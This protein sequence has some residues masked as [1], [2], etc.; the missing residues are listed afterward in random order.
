[1]KIKS[2]RDFW[3]G[4]MFIAVGVGFAIGALDYSMG[5]PCTDAAAPCA[6]SLVAR[7][8]QLSARPGAGF[9]PLG[10]S[11]VLALLGLLVTFKS[12]TIETPGGDPVGAFAWR[13]LVVVIV[14]ILTFGILLEPA[15]LLVTVPLVVIIVSFAV[16]EARIVPTLVI[17]A[18]LTVFSWA[19]FVKGLSLTIPVLPAFLS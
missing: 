9:F 12:L 5:P 2:E 17:A 1:M 8:Q 6:Q 15:G 3:S 14:A 18:V 16:R 7:F 10:L 11:V 13:P 19:V 4:L